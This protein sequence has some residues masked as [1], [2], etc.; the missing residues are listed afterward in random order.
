M[1]AFVSIQLQTNTLVRTVFFE[2]FIVRCTRGGGVG[3]GWLPHGSRVAVVQL[4]LHPA[5][6]FGLWFRNTRGS[7]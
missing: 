5:F 4:R 6:E 1:W 7:P 3:G 2:D